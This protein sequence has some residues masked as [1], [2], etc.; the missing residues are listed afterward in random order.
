MRSY[1]SVV[2]EVDVTVAEP[3]LFVVVVVGPAVQLGAWT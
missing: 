3:V 2:G 1:V